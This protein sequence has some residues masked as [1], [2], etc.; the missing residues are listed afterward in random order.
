MGALELQLQSAFARVVGLVVE[1][2]LLLELL[3]GSL[4]LLLDSLGVLA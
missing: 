2:L 4:K 3:L 1:S